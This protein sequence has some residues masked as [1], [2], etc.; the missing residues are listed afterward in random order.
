MIDA[1]LPSGTI[2]VSYP[3][4]IADTTGDADAKDGTAV[5]KLPDMEE[6]KALTAP[7]GVTAEEMDAGFHE[8]VQSVTALSDNG[9]VTGN[10]KAIE[11]LGAAVKANGLL[12]EGEKVSISLEQQLKDVTFEPIVKLS[13]DGSILSVVISPKH[14]VYEITAH[15]TLLDAE[16]NPIEGTRQPIDLSSGIMT[17]KTNFRF[18]LPVP[19]GVESTYANV[20]HEGDPVRQYTIEKEGSDQFI[21]VTAWHLSEFVL[22]FTNDKLVQ[23][24]SSSKPKSSGAGN[25]G[26]SYKDMTANKT[27]EWV[28]DEAG[29]WF[30]YDDGT[31]PAG[32]WAELGWNNVT[33]W[34]YFNA[35]GYMAAGW[36]KDGENWYYLHPHSDGTQGFM[37]TGWHEI[38]GRWYYFSTAAG[39]PLGAM[40]ADTTTPGGDHVGADGAWIP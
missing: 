16:G 33:K 37:Y 32:T 4:I 11:N 24:G 8:A 19:S 31:W 7:D 12:E 27:G 22:N 18:R 26:G 6:L 36:K 21:T 2:L 39:G 15:K 29:W 10:E 17:K 38:D 3:V 30:K 5:V 20:E 25:K 40:A 1:V 34:Y 35:D 28:H 9:A 23:S 13:A 14:M